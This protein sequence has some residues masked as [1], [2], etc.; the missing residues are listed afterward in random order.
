MIVSLLLALLAILALGAS[1]F[2]SG[3]ETAFLSV[4]RGRII[5]LAREG[6]RAA[7]IVLAALRD[8]NTT[9][10]SILI[11]NN[12]ANVV[13]SA[14][15]AEL[16]ARLCAAAPWLDGAWTALSAFIVLYLSEFLPKLFCSTRPLTR[17]LLLAPPFLSFSR[18]IYPLTRIAMAVT[19]IFI[20]KSE[21]KERVTV[22]DLMR[23]LKDR[24]D[25]VKLTDFESALISRILELRKKN[26]LITVE[27][28]LTALDEDLQD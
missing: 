4:S 20:P 1:A 17:I 16:G 6:S 7:G 13:Y 21:V 9:M 11:A 27:S 19:S 22:N 2:C 25:G 23:I 28:L 12:I 14:A 24:K 8:M 26:E 10:T 3:S 5:H 15:A 18:L